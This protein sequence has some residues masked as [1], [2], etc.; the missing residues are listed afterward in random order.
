MTPYA[1]GSSTKK[2]RRGGVNADSLE[3]GLE[4]GENQEIVESEEEQD[5]SIDNMIKVNRFFF[6][7]V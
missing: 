3:L 4:E 6:N 2:T 7:I 1:V 5:L